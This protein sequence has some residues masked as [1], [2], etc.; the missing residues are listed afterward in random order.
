MKHIQTFAQFLNEA[1]VPWEIESLVDELSQSLA[2]RG[3][4]SRTQAEKFL[5]SPIGKEEAESTLKELKGLKN[6][7]TKWDKIKK[8]VIDMILSSPDLPNKQFTNEKIEYPEGVKTTGDKILDKLGKLL[9]S[10]KGIIEVGTGS[11]RGKKV[12]FFN[13]DAY[14]NITGYREHWNL[15]CSNGDFE[16][17]RKEIKNAE[18][19]FNQIE[20]AIQMG[21]VTIGNKK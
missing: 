2:N 5:L 4:W 19:L 7:N 3:L 14:F 20:K 11:I 17:P 12:P 21:T 15:L 10:P 9:N 1:N 8:E 13:G 6:H 16:F 18:E